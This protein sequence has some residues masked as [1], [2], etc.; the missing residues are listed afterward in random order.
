VDYVTR[1]EILQL[2]QDAQMLVAELRNPRDPSRLEIA[3]RIL[4][5]MG[6]NAFQD[7]ITQKEFETTS[8]QS[9]LRY[10]DALIAEHNATCGDPAP[11][12]GAE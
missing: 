3:S 7:G 6:V 4:A 8:V 2:L 11:V 12:T 9:A 10:A 1:A 5:G